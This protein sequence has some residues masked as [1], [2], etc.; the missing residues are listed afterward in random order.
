MIKMDWW[1]IV[2]IVLIVLG[3]IEFLWGF[4]TCL[5]LGLGHMLTKNKLQNFIVSFFLGWLIVP[6]MILLAIMISA[7]L[8]QFEE[9]E[10]NSKSVD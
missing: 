8:T 1:E 6:I 5:T 9:Y 7:R 2:K 3:C 4:I 10:N